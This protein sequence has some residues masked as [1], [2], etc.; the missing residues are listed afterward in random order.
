MHAVKKL[1]LCD[2]KCAGFVLLS[3]S[4]EAGGRGEA[5]GRERRK[6]TDGPGGWCCQGGEQFLAGSV[7]SHF[8][9]A[10]W[11][12][13]WKKCNPL[14]SWPGKGEWETPSCFSDQGSEPRQELKP[15]E[16]THLGFCKRKPLRKCT[17][18][19]WELN[20][21]MGVASCLVL[22]KVFLEAGTWIPTVFMSFH[23]P[24]SC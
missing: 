10:V 13:L 20:G 18:F 3:S 22:I 17:R 6:Q 8:C 7:F 16:Y 2:R 14:G 21:V 15:L 5:T 12:C 9:C 19:N 1:S 23:C 11:C 4:Q 24:V